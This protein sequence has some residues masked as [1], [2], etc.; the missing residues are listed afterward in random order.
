MRKYGSIYFTQ[1][2]AVQR[3]ATVYYDFFSFLSLIQFN[4]IP[5]KFTSNRK[6]SKTD[7]KK[8][9]ISYFLFLCLAGKYFVSEHK[10]KRGHRNC[11]S[12]GGAANCSNAVSPLTHRLQIHSIAQI[13]G[14]PQSSDWHLQ[15]SSDVMLWCRGKTVSNL[16]RSCSNGK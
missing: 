14:T 16:T 13:Y 1:P 9:H 10:V 7:V 15:E 3:F 8:W 12:H 6:D 11:T 2:F 5:F 4:S